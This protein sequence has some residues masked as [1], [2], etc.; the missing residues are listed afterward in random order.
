MLNK[1]EMV[2]IKRNMNGLLISIRLEKEMPKEWK[3][4]HRYITK[5][6][7]NIGNNM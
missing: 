3:D 1:V 4:I 6:F 5:E 2:E 7:K